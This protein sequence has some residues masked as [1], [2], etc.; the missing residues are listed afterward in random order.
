MDVWAGRE[1][2]PTPAAVK[3]GASA[4]EPAPDGRPLIADAPGGESTEWKPAFKIAARGPHPPRATLD[5]LAKVLR[6]IKVLRQ[7][8]EVELS[9]REQGRP[10]GMPLLLPIA[11][12]EGMGCR[13][14]GLQVRPIY[15]DRAAGEVFPPTLR[16]L[17]RG[18]SR[19][20]KQAF[21]TF[22]RAHTSVR[23][24]HYYALGRRAMV[25]A[26]WEV[27]RRLAEIGDSF[28]FLLQ[29]TPVNAE[30]AWREFRRGSFQRPPVFLY[31]P[32]AVEPALLKRRLFEIPIERI[33][34]PTLAH[35]FGERQDELDRKITMLSDM[36]TP[37]FLLGS[38]QIYGG[39]EPGLS[40]LAGRLLAAM[41]RRSR[42]R[43]AGRELSADQFAER[44]RAEV[45]HYRRSYPEFTATVTVRDDMYWGLLVS[46]GDLLIGKHT[47]IPAD[48][49]EALLQHEIGTHLVTYYN[50]R[51][52]PFRQLR[53]GLAGYESLQEGIAVLAEY[54]VGGLNRPRMRLLAA[55]VLAAQ[56]LVEGASFVDT[57]RLLSQA[58]GLPQRVAYTVAMRVYRG[59]GL[60]KDVVYLRGLV[61]ML[62]YL[63]RGGDLES[64]LVGK[65]GADHIPLVRE[66]HMRQILRT[67]PLKPR[68]LEG[69]RSLDR[70][71]RLQEGVSV[72][73]LAEGQEG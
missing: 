3:A 26:V 15:R 5:T 67:P 19:A 38:L 68:Y 45:D 31:R 29:V 39:I 32:L 53:S 18:L 65:I 49:V 52:Q 23:P 4:Q 37:R 24:Q 36:G 8:A 47:R 14:I 22:A 66:L 73:Q 28:D 7:A 20:L 56:R 70:L 61:E 27:D 72:E 54:L 41:P 69:A 2:R 17:R 42:K 60:A 46:G 9:E 35:L 25:K 16:V 34:D 64:L 10:P 63:R 11:E 59:G 51:A 50:G 6:R 30:A 21:F 40:D 57:F 48:R 55:R 71:R 44:A 13:L 1:S 43:A 33:E 62:D 12:M 58:H